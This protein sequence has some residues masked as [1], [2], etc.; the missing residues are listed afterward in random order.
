MCGNGPQ[1]QTYHYPV[2]GGGPHPF[3]PG[4]G[5]GSGKITGRFA[6]LFTA[7]LHEPTCRWRRWVL[8]PGRIALKG[9]TP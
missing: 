3:T 5:R 8:Q 4:R 9:W 7:E 2:R 6:R 1:G